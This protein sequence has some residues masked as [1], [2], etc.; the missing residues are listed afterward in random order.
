MTS[1]TYS[2]CHLLSTPSTNAGLRSKEQINVKGVTSGWKSNIHFNVNEPRS[3]TFYDFMTEHHGYRF[4]KYEIQRY[5]KRLYFKKLPQVSEKGRIRY[6][7]TWPR[8]PM[9]SY[10]DLTSR[11]LVVISEFLLRSSVFENKPRCSVNKDGFVR[12]VLTEYYIKVN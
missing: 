6:D 9:L 4:G 12:K 2:E 11:A 1:E 10:H 8:R 3:H 5:K 7:Y